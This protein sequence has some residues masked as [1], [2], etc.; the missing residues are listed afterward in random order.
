MNNIHHIGYVV[1]NTDNQFEM[2]TNFG[3]QVE[4]DWKF[5]PIQNV[6]CSLLSAPFQSNVELVAPS[7]EGKNPLS[8]RLRRGGGLDHFCYLTDDLELSIKNELSKNSRLILGRTFA[9]TFNKDISFVMRK[10]GLI[11]EYME[12]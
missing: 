1:P 2:W 7:S 10:S 4:I 12:V 8:S 3:F 5:D 11:V 6:F 9:C